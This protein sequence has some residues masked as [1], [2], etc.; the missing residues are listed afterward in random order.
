M[1]IGIWIPLKWWIFG[2][3]ANYLSILKVAIRFL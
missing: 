3:F 2:C 1:T